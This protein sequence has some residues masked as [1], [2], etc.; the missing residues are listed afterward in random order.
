MPETVPICS[1]VRFGAFEV[2][3]RKGE[4]HKNGLKLRLTGQPFQVLALLVEHPGQVVSREELCKRLWTDD[5]F[6]DIDHGLNAVVNRLREVLGDSPDSPRFIETVPREGYRFIAMIEGRRGGIPAIEADTIFRREPDTG[7]LRESYLQTSTLHQSKYFW[8]V[9]LTGTVLLVML[10]VFN[11][12]G[13]RDWFVSPSGVAPI[14][15]IAVLPLD[16]LS[17][18]PTQEYFADGITDALITEL[19]RVSALRVISRRSVMRYK[20]SKKPLPEIARELGVEALV[21]GSAMRAGRRVAVTASLIEAFSDKHIWSQRYDRELGD[22]LTIQS[23]FAQAIAR[24][25][26][27][28]LTPSERARLAS[29]RIVNTDAYELYL[30]GQ[31]FAAKGTEEGRKKAIRYFEQ[32]IEIDPNNSLAYAGI[33]GSYAPLG[34]YGFVSPVES[35]NKT[36]WAA[37]KALELDDTLSEAH[38]WLGLARSVHEWDWSTGEREL[39]RAIELN[40]G[41]ASAHSL[42]AQILMM[43]GRTQES[44]AESKEARKLDPLSPILYALW[45]ERLIWTRQYDQAIEKCQ[46]AIELDPTYPVAQLR[47]GVAYEAKGEYEKAITELETARDLSVRAPYFLRSLGHAYATAGRKGQAQQILQELRRDSAKRYV[48]P[49]AF[50][51]IYTGLGEKEQAFDWLEKAYQHRDPSLS[52]IRGDPRLDP[53]R[54]DPRFQ[55]LLRRVHLT[56]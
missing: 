13:W 1:V 34:Y 8:T 30:K 52:T 28:K 37:T 26:E 41:Y 10:V 12:T 51:L 7:K 47:L 4:L 22:I 39:Q 16:N 19:G 23:D 38:A 6:V 11:V 45:A 35:D 50:A 5:T 46:K 42:Y 20:G 53:L 43:T 3:L 55:D 44:A 25:V 21:E 48:S 32:A 18:D 14:R 31:S 9:G 15:S 56:P 24:E 36:V 2:D 29:R 27:A 54:G 17:G 33:A 40:P 49:F